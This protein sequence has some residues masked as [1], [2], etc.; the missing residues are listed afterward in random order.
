MGVLS[1]DAIM[2]TAI[3]LDLAQDN[4]RMSD[5]QLMRNE[6]YLYVT[7]SLN[8]EVDFEKE[9]MFIGFDTYQ[10]N[11]GE[12]YYDTKFFGNALSGMEFIVKFESKSAASLYCVPSYNRSKARL[13]SVESYTAVYE[14]VAPLRYGSF[15]T[16]NTQFFQTGNTVH[17]RVPWAMLN[18]S[19]P[20]QLI[21]LNDTT[22]V[23]NDAEDTYETTLTTG[24]IVSVF[25]GDI[26]SKDTN[27]V[28][29]SDKQSPG[30]K[31]YEWAAWKKENVTYGIAEKSAVETLRKYFAA[32]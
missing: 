24:A 25:I 26:E 8:S 11:N 32:Y 15:A 30:F 31:R 7:V 14:L 22:A 6:S 21:V 1:V 16:Q 9:Q 4:E 12:Y 13:S 27:Y 28:F 3:G 10:R 20:S 5:M 2:P 29:P 17:L 18:I 19:D 23:L